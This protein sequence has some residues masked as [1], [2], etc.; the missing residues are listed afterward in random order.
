MLIRFWCIL[1]K[2]FRCC[3]KFL[4]SYTQ[5]YTTKLRAIVPNMNSFMAIILK[6]KRFIYNSNSKIIIIFVYMGAIISPTGW[7]N[8]H[9]E[10]FLKLLSS[11]F[12]IQYAYFLQY[13]PLDFQVFIFLY[14]FL[15]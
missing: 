14:C 2:K 11:C 7:S 10:N 4:I 12:S 6:F 1:L 8:T 5:W 15:K 13:F 9:W 3:T